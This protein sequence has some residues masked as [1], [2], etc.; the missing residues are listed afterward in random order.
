MGVRSTLRGW[1]GGGEQQRVA[2]ITSAEDLLNERRRSRAS[3]GVAITSDSAMRHSAVWACL[4]LRADLVSTMPVDEYRKTRFLGVDVQTSVKTMPVLVN[5]GGAR[6]GIKEWLYS[7]QVDLDRA[8]NCF[9]VISERNGLGLPAR[10]D[11]VGLS[12]VIVRARG[13]E[14]YEYEIAGVKYNEE[15]GRLRDVWHEKQFTVAGSPLGLSPVAHAAWTL[16]EAFG[17]QKFALDWFGGKAVPMAS[18]KNIAKVLAPGEART[19]KDAF[20]A[21]VENG[22]L[23]VHGRDWEY[24]P[25][26]AVAQQSEFL[27][28]RGFA[29]GDIARF[30][31]CP[32][33][34]ID[35]AVSTGSITYATI[36]QRN[37]QFLI[38]HLDPALSRREDALTTLTPSPHYVKLNR[39]KLLAMDP[40]TRAATNKVR[41][42]SRTLTPNE[43]RALEDMAP[44]TDAQYDEFDRAFGGGSGSASPLTPADVPVDE[45]NGVPA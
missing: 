1:L 40:A 7:T 38:M 8:G 2:S 3:R 32:G 30:F 34:T 13:A 39:G 42:D 17:A 37:L 16:E 33:D 21:A 41:I 11:L 28:T 14:I 19:A 35:A 9:G 23:F 4:R 43:A 25:I 26:Q 5:P 20:N 45:T 18:L 29:L 24:K 22:E 27:A 44:L 31:G 6:V 10:I 12:D 36:T 15:N